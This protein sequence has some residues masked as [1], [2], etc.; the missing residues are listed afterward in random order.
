[1]KRLLGFRFV[2]KEDKRIY[3]LSLFEINV[4]IGFAYRYSDVCIERGERN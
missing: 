2:N 4:C 1:M 3:I